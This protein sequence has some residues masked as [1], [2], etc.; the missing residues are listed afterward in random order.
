MWSNTASGASGD[1][2][3]QQVLV[4]SLTNDGSVIADTGSCFPEIPTPAPAPPPSVEPP[5]PVLTEPHLTG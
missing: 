5:P 2:V 3:G 4:G 1:A